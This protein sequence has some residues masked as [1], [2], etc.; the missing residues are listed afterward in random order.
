MS[1]AR[2]SK[3]DKAKK[4]PSE[5]HARPETIIKH[6]NNPDRIA[7]ASS[8]EAVGDQLNTH[9]R[10]LAATQNDMQ[11]GR[12]DLPDDTVQDAASMTEKAKLTRAKAIFLGFMLTL[13]ALLI[14]AA[15]MQFVMAAKAW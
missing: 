6:E 2:L 1:K 15:I 9:E 5:A 4:A 12:I 7:S 11:Q 8:L 10:S 3:L 13:S 14:A